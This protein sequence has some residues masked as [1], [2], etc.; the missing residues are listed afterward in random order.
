MCVCVCVC[1]CARVY[2]YMSV[3]VFCGGVVLLGVWEDY[4]VV[5]REGV[6]FV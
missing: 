1:V 3:C 2:A 6:A 5:G 4:E